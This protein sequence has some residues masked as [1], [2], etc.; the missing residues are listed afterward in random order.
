MFILHR[1][2]GQDGDASLVFLPGIAGLI[3]P[4]SCLFIGAHPGNGGFEIGG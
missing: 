1:L 3:L 2:A 4:E